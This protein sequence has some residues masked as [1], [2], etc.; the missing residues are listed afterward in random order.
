MNQHAPTP[1]PGLHVLFLVDLN[2][3]MVVCPADVMGAT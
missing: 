3:A 2:A 1:P